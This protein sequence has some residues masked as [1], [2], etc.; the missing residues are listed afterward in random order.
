MPELGVLIVDDEPMAAQ[1]H[2]MFVEGTP[3]FVVTGVAYSGEEAVEMMTS[4][5]PDVVLLDLQLPGI[6]GID[7][8]RMLRTRLGN[9]VD[10]IA[11]TADRRARSIDQMRML[12]VAHYLAKPFSVRE[13]RTQLRSVARVRTALASRQSFDGQADIDGVIHNGFVEIGASVARPD[14]PTEQD[15]LAGHPLDALRE[16]ADRRIADH[17][18]SVDFTLHTLADTL[19]VSARQL[20][21]AYARADR[22]VQDAIRDH[23]VGVAAM[24]ILGAERLTMTE[25]ARRSGFS[26]VRTM[27]RAFQE[28]HGVPPARWRAMQ[29][30]AAKEPESRRKTDRTRPGRGE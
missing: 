14:D 11:V 30:H 22:A 5:P 4:E 25:V 3:G 16:L 1:L 29:T 12:G 21:R 18:H 19:H 10:V 7:V 20:Q 23:R 17:G 27:R 6:S 8:L 15:I 13:L 28:V 9:E 2:R 24:L 26:C